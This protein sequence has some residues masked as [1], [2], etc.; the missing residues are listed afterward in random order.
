VIKRL[1]TGMML[2]AMISGCATSRQASESTSATAAPV[3]AAAPVP[4]TAAEGNQANSAGDIPD[5]QTFVAYAGPGYSVLVPEGWSR[6]QRGSTVTFT[7]NAN[8]EAVDIGKPGDTTAQLRAR[9]GA[10]GPIAFRRA[11]IGG[12]PVT[13]AGFT[14]RSAPN[15]VT[16]KSVRLENNA[17]VFDRSGR[18]AVLVLSAPAGADNADQWKKISESFRWK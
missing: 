14:S 1:L 16:G 7:W 4:T 3:I 18:R 10:A 13:V 12:T 15:A 9:F 11:A 8:A 6:T 2:A 17:Y 5:T